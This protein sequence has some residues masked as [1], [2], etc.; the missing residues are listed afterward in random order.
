MHLK[1]MLAVKIEQATRM[2]TISSPSRETDKGKFLV[3]GSQEL[4]ASNTHEE[5]DEHTLMPS[6]RICLS[7][8]TPAVI[9]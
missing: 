5:R 1:T 7:T 9:L 4:H 8:S 3:R 2:N 6:V